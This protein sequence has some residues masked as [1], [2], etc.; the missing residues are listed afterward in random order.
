M[1]SVHKAQK[2][3]F[4]SCILNSALF[5]SAIR[6]TSD[7]KANPFGVRSFCILIYKSRFWNALSLI[8][9]YQIDEVAKKR[10][11]SLKEI[12]NWLG[13][14]HPRIC[15]IV[16]MLLLSPKI[17]EEILL[18]DNKALFNI[19]EYKLRDIMAEASWDK[20]QEVWNKLVKSC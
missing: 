7:R 3:C 20:Q 19:P 17:Q 14:N 8:L 16:N 13:M 5:L 2:I 9:G 6:T 10:D 12:A 18:S 4:N 15:Q 1:H 11:R